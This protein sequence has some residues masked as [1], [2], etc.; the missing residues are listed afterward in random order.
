MA[1]ALLINPDST[2]EPI[3]LPDE[4]GLRSKAIATRLSGSPDP[5]NYHRRALMWVHGNGANEGLPPN[6]T[7]TALASAWR[8]LDIGSSY[9]LYGSV[10]VTGAEYGDV[11]PLEED[12]A[13]QAQAVA[14][15]VVARRTAWQTEQPASNEAAWAEILQCAFRAVRPGGSAE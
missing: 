12:L 8:G 5:G 1:S 11:A 7:A 6:L 2:V 3:D 10:I 14:E 4:P 13:G 9:F 15:A